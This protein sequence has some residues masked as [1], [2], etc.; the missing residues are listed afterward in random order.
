M[1]CG[2]S[3]PYISS[4]RRS[5]YSENDDDDEHCERGEKV[6]THI[7]VS[8]LHPK[9]SRKTEAKNGEITTMRANRNVKPELK[10]KSDRTLSG[11]LRA[12][13]KRTPSQIEFFRALDEKINLDT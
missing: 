12:Q 11:P 9:Y 6:L 4:R 5:S 3:K 1:G 13:V 7:G 2:P 10:D 8:R